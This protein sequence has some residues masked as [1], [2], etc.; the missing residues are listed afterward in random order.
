MDG[1]VKLKLSDLLDRPNSA[2]LAISIIISTRNESENIEILLAS[3]SRAMGGVPAAVVFVDDS[4]DHIAELIRNLL[5]QFPLKVSG[6]K[7]G[8]H[9]LEVRDSTLDAS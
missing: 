8:A 5:D 9:D 3:L 4:S 2:E 7:I 6:I 1:V